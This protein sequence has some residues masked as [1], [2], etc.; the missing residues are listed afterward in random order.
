M[1]RRAVY[2][3]Q[4]QLDTV[5]FILSKKQILDRREYIH[6]S[7]HVKHQFI[8]FFDKMKILFTEKC[9]EEFYSTSTIYWEFQS[10]MGTKKEEFGFADV[11]KL[12]T[13]IFASIRDRIVKKILLMAVDYFI[14]SVLQRQHGCQDI[15]NA[16]NQLGDEQ[17]ED[18]FQIIDKRK[19]VLEEQ[20][21]LTSL[22]NQWEQY[23]I[24]LFGGLMVPTMV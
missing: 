16:V 4:R 7:H 12:A 15:Q 21:K 3:C 5:E 19:D 20:S 13:Q 11:R 22:L 23:E 9:M 8:K 10:S 2:I 14:F 17:L 6:F 18:L 1:S 24:I